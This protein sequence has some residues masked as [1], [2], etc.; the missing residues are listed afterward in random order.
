MAKY[1]LLTKN[2]HGEVSSIAMT[3]VYAVGPEGVAQAAKEKLDRE[4][5]RQ[6]YDRWVKDGK[7]FRLEAQ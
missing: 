7:L 3:Y 4:G 1:A 6:Y 2:V 5:R